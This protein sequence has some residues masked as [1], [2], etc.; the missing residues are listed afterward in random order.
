MLSNVDIVNELKKKNIAI[1]PLGKDTIKG[2]SINLT[3]SDMA[4]SYNTK[5]II[6]PT[7]VEIK[8]NNGNVT[9]TVWDII[10]PA[11]DT[12]IIVTNETIAV[13]NKIGGTYHS[14]VY[15]VSEGKGHIGTTLNPGWVGRSIIAVNN[16]SDETKTVRVNDPFVTVIF[17]YFKTPTT[18]KEDNKPHR[19][20]IIHKLKL[21]SNDKY[22]N[23]VASPID[24]ETYL[25]SYLSKNNT[26]PINVADIKQCDSYYNDIVKK[27]RFKNF[28][29]KHGFKVITVV[30]LWICYFFVSYINNNNNLNLD[31]KIDT[32]FGIVIG[33]TLL[34]ITRI[35]EKKE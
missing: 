24:C 27:H 1:S 30:A 34:P 22:E 31:S 17:D 28:C 2:A 5:K 23:I 26:D 18:L 13:S 35:I 10:I 6:K 8:D 16:P 20:D 14:R 32:F 3:A 25:K 12:A 29:I 7:K 15:D 19:E 33:T 9:N 21:E 4:W 11:K